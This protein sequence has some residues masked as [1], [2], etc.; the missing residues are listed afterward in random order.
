MD[1]LGI[2][3][4]TYERRESR[5]SRISHGMEKVMQMRHVDKTRSRHL[6]A[7]PAFLV[8]RDGITKIKHKI[9]E[10]IH[11]DRSMIVC[12]SDLRDTTFYVMIDSGGNNF[13]A[14]GG[15]R[16]DNSIHVNL[17]VSIC[18]VWCQARKQSAV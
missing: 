5:R 7:G 11:T 15:H 8:H 14:Y 13:P 1:M 16:S 6:Y 17:S 12:S 4:L 2:L 9:K 18:D 3:V 10:T